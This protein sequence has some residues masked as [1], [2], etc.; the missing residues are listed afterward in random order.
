MQDVEYA[1]TLGR[2]GALH[3]FR[4]WTLLTSEVQIWTI[5]ESHVKYML[6]GPGFE[7]FTKG[8]WVYERMY[9]V[10]RL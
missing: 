10:G 6:A 1:N 4:V 2:P 7:F 8:Y 9:V 3:G 5:D